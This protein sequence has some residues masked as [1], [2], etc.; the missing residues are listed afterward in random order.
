MCALITR[1][2]RATALYV[3]VSVFSSA[4]EFMCV[5]YF[6]QY[7]GTNS[8]HVYVHTVFVCM[9]LYSI[10]EGLSSHVHIC[11]CVC[12]CV[13]VCVSLH[14][15]VLPHNF[16]CVYMMCFYVFFHVLH[17]FVFMYYIIHGKTT[18]TVFLY[19]VCC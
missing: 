8:M 15:C 11:Q 19:V 12:V 1:Y 13:C 18:Y 9:Y 14:V 10:F 4:L 7:E 6:R 16:V 3:C 2:I 17:P 5:C